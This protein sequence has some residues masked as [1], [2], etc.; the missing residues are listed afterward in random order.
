MTVILLFST[1]PRHEDFW[2]TD[3]ATFA[4]NG[5][6]VR[7]YITRGFPNSLMT[8]ANAWFLRYPALTISLYPPIFPMA[9]A[10]VFALFG[11]SHPAAQA[12]VA[13]FTA[14]AAYGAY[15]TARTVVSPLAAAGFALVLFATPGVL[16]WSRQVMMEIPSLAFL[17]IGAVTLLRYQALGGTWRLQLAVLMVL[18]GVYTKQTAIFAAPA[19]IAALLLEEGPGLLRRRAVWLAMLVGGVGLLPLVAFTL[20]FASQTIDIAMRQGSALAID[21][22]SHTSVVALTVYA[23]ALPNIVGWLPLLCALSYLAFV[24]VRGWRS[25]AEKRLVV[26]MLSWF[27]ADYVFISFIGHFEERYGMALTVPPAAL[28]ILLVTRLV[29]ERLSSAI[30]L[31][32][33]AALFVFSLATNPVHWVKGYGAVASSILSHTAQDDVVLFDGNDS[34]SLVF[35]L[36]SRSPTP[37]IYVLRAEKLL[38]DYSIVREWGI[39]DRNLSTGDIEAVIDRFGVSLVVLQPDFW[40]DQ[41]SMARLQSFISSDRFEPIAEFEIMAQEQNKRT[42]IKIFRNK[43]PRRATDEIIRQLETRQQ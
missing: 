13:A 36:R 26:L 30:A 43:Y 16:L 25:L 39:K 14:L 1:S 23:R 5:E 6:F 15:L 24:T 7:D 3:A 21:G 37:K 29:Q 18:A 2:W 40:T 31:A 4:L 12:T 32:G 8:F 38:V 28:S 27:A 35:S 9:E 17:L 20:K 10:V 42:T 22:P 19:F 11:F 33:G 34:K 41:P